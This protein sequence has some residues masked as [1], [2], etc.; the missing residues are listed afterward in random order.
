VTWLSPPSS[1]LPTQCRRVQAHFGR[2]DPPQI[3]SF[4]E[5]TDSH[6]ELDRAVADE[7]DEALSLEATLLQPERRDVM[8]E[9]LAVSMTMRTISYAPAETGEARIARTAC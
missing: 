1:G 2:N 8:V 9:V 3:A 6:P 4:A 5:L 7:R